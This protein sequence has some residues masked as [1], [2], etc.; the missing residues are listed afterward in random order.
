MVK[1]RAQHIFRGDCPVAKQR[2]NLEEN[3]APKPGR[4]FSS[5]SISGTN[6]ELRL[7]RPLCH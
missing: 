1:N 2:Y 4:L 5:G 3:K 6:R 7:L